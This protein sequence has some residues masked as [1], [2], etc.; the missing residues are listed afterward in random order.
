MSL[1]I[2]KVI[3]FKTSLFI[4]TIQKY[5]LTKENKVTNSCGYQN[6]FLWS[7]F[8]STELLDL[9][10]LFVSVISK[11]SLTLKQKMSWF[12]AAGAVHKSRYIWERNAFYI[13][14]SVLNEQTSV[15]NTFSFQILFKNL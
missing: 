1:P 5:S 3:G 7:R 9:P 10:F 2:T 15:Q 8:N 11:T 14:K 13:P 12:Q 6:T 4:Q